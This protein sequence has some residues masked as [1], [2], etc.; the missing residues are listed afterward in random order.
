MAD[1]T[2][3]RFFNPLERV[4]HLK[5]MGLFARLPAAD[6]AALADGAEERAFRR[7]SKVFTEG[8]RVESVLAIIEGEVSVSARGRDLGRIG[9][10]TPLG[11][12]SLLADDD[13]GIEAVAMAPT[14]A[15]EIPADYFFEVLEDHFPLFHQVLRF[16]SGLI[17]DI[18]TTLDTTAGFAGDGP[19]GRASDEAPPADRE[20]N[21]VERI[22]HLRRLT[23]FQ[24]ASIEALAELGH[25]QSEKRLGAGEVLW[26]GGDRSGTV[27]FVL[28]GSIQATTESGQEFVFG[29]LS[30]L[31]ALDSLAGR[32][33]WF[34]AR[35]LAPVVLLEETTEILLDVFEDNFDMARQFVASLASEAQS[36]VAGAPLEMDRPLELAW[37]DD[38]HDD[39]L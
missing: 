13:Q 35:T 12:I 2:T 20:L 33:R 10:G 23:V 28:S 22:L 9:P 25:L 5:S 16:L 11:A 1:R 14:S 31:G 24:Q 17:I 8:S 38:H 29:P 39:P 19:P 3:M 4:L 7:G 34:T 37:E 32:S 30:A 36:L 21:L 27:A 18:R 6:L 26:N 15:L